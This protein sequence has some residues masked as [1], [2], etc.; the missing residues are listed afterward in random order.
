MIEGEASVIP[1]PVPKSPTVSVDGAAYIPGGSGRGRPVVEA[2][3]AVSVE[4]ASRLS[5]RGHYRGSDAEQRRCNDQ[6]GPGQHS[7][8]SC[9]V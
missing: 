4:I 2:S 5:L 6:P 8:L 3:S 7:Q 1:I 9:E